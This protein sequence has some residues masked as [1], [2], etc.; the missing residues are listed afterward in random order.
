MYGLCSWIREN[1]CTI[2]CLLKKGFPKTDLLKWS[3]LH[4][5]CITIVAPS[6]YSVLEFLLSF[7]F[8][9]LKSKF[10]LYHP[11]TSWFDLAFMQRACC[12]YV[13]M[14]PMLHLSI[15]FICHQIQECNFMM[16]LFSLCRLTNMMVL[17]TL[18]SFVVWPV[19]TLF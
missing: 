13:V 6:D 19:E 4:N 3:I 8:I 2:D 1:R 7:R 12:A 5:T 14:F 10:S 18:W 15:L 17:S 11:V 16:N 9:V